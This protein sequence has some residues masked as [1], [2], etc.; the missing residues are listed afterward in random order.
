MMQNPPIGFVTDLVDTD[1]AHGGHDP[2]KTED[3]ICWRMLRI[4]HGLDMLATEASHD[5][6]TQE[7]V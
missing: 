4:F 3:A 6:A 7:S 1:S 5:G 2:I